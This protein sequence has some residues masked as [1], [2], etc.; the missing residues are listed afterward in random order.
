MIYSGKETPKV[1]NLLLSK[2]NIS[3][4]AATSE[5]IITPFIIL[6]NGFFFI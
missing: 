5:A 2:T 1:S 3:N 4:S 6:E